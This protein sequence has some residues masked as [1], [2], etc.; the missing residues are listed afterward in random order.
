MR[1]TTFFRGLKRGGSEQRLLELE[2]ELALKRRRRRGELCL[3]EIMTIVVGVHLSGYRTFKS[4]YLGQVLRY[5]RP[6]YPGLVSYN[7][8]VELL[9]GSLMP[10]CCF[11]VSRFGRCSGISFI[12]STKISVCHNRRIGSHKVMAEFAAWGKTSTQSFLK[13]RLKLPILSSFNVEWKWANGK[14]IH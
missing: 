12:D 8:F 9:P 6:Y 14:E 13:C 10:L 5:Q 4:C 1:L 3:S 2:L 7:R 11:L